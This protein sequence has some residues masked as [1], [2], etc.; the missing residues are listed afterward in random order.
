VK[1]RARAVRAHLQPFMRYAT[2]RQSDWRITGRV[3]TGLMV[4][5]WFI[6]DPAWTVWALTGAYFLV[7][8]LWLHGAIAAYRA[9]GRHEIHDR[10]DINWR[11]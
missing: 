3:V 4:F 8:L 1:G 10:N 2:R 11:L 7:R 9:G 5:A 6:G